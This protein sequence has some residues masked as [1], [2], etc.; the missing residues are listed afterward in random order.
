M[1]VIFL[2]LFISFIKIKALKAYEN[3]SNAIDVKECLWKNM[4][5][6][7]K[8]VIGG[9]PEMKIE[10]LDPVHSNNSIVVNEMIGATFSNYTLT[11]FT[12]FSIKTVIS[13]YYKDD[14]FMIGLKLIF[15]GI[16]G[17]GKYCL[18]WNFGYFFPH[19]SI[20]EG[21]VTFETC[22]FFFSIIFFVTYPNYILDDL[23]LYFIISGKYVNNIA[24][25]DDLELNTKTHFSKINLMNLFGGVKILESLGNSIINRNI[26]KF[27][28]GT[29]KGIFAYFKPL[30]L[31]NVKIFLSKRSKT[32]LLSYFPN[33]SVKKN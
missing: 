30:L 5:L 22:K 19:K 17:K 21:D 23:E 6:L 33:A 14:S 31:K 25:I 9:D 28:K 18:K 2:I 29:I 15:P 1:K 4:N 13:R 16:E 12:K 3:C 11:G 20:F 32:K 24:Q 27:E 7:M 26:D 10:K 8:T